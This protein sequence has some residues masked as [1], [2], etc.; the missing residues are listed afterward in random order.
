MGSAGAVGTYAATRSSSTTNKC[1]ATMKLD[2][3]PTV[4]KMKTEARERKLGLPVS[5]KTTSFQLCATSGNIVFNGRDRSSAT[6]DR[7]EGL[8]DPFVF[9]IANKV[10]P[11]KMNDST[12]RNVATGFFSDVITFA[13]SD[14]EAFVGKI[15]TVRPRT[16]A[17]VADASRSTRKERSRRTSTS[18]QPR[19]PSICTRPKA[20]P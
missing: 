7:W 4:S 16:S 2:M 3:T 6:A 12:R 1:A 20:A 11:L 15:T 13:T 17:R 18:N 10:V 19:G 9:S 8:S 5:G 14:T